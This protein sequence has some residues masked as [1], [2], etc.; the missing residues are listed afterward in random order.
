MEE[1]TRR[2]QSD[3]KNS[4]HSGVTALTLVCPLDHGGII[5]RG[6]I[7]FLASMSKLQQVIVGLY[8]VGVAYCCLWVPWYTN[9]AR[10]NHYQ[11]GYAPLWSSAVGDF[12]Q[13]DY[14]M[15]GLRLLALTA[16]AVARAKPFDGDLHLTLLNL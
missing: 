12:G 5:A 9:A 7:G 15:V 2:L 3:G 16:I 6:G 10:D 1:H 13:P 4:T 8:C 11:L 14:R